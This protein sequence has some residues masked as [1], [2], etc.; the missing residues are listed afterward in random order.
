MQSVLTRH[1]TSP[2]HDLPHGHLERCQ[3]CGGGGSCPGARSRPPAAPAISLAQPPRSSMFAEPDLHRC[4]LPAVPRFAGL[5]PDRLTRYRPEIPFPSPTIPYRSGINRHGWCVNPAE[6]PHR[7]SSI[8]TVFRR[9]GPSCIDIGSN[10]GTLLKG[11]RAKGD[12]SARHRGDQYLRRWPMPEGIETIQ[13]LLQRGRRAQHHRKPRPTPKAIHRDQTCSRMS[14]NLGDLLARRPRAS[15]PI[16]RRLRHRIALP[17]RPDRGPAQYDSIY[18]EHLKY[19]ALK[20]A[21]SPLLLLRPSSV[22]DAEKNPELRRLGSAVYAIKGNGERSARFEH[23]A[24]RGKDR[25]RGIYGESALSPA[26]PSLVRRLE[27]ST[28]R[29]SCLS[30]ALAGEDPAPGIG[31]PGPLQHRCSTTAISDRDLMPYIAEQSN[32]LKLGLFL[33]GKTHP[34]SST[35]PRL[36]AEQAPTTPR[37]A[38]LALCGTHHPQHAAEGGCARRSSCRCRHFSHRRGLSRLFAAPCG[39]GIAGTGF[40]FLPAVPYARACNRF[41][42][43]HRRGDCR[44]RDW[45]G[46]PRSARNHGIALFACRGIEEFARPGPRRGYPSPFL[47]HS[48]RRPPTLAARFAAFAIFSPRNL[49]R[50]KRRGRRG[51]GCGRAAGRTAMVDFEF[52]EAARHFRSLR[53]VIASGELGPHRVDRPSLG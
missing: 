13:G 51:A 39:I 27:S 24:R 35:R 31:C 2:Q 5:A 45:T 37:H 48:P 20:A 49:W 3:I 10:D 15:S 32:S 7:P 41:L 23:A 21:H 4:V 6:K 8:H 12:A 1:P 43:S 40:W 44:K 17:A 50:D 18:H 19:Y 22:T 29:D 36:F 47:R 52:A 26:S 33:P 28:C 25:G 9:G 34:R 53:D 11:F 46:L 42:V 38:V 16:G 14:R 30:R